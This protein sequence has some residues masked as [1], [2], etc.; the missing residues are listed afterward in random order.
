MVD[1]GQMLG[2]NPIDGVEKDSD[3][4]YWTLI[5]HLDSRHPESD[6]DKTIHN[7]ILIMKTCLRCYFVFGQSHKKTTFQVH[8][9]NSR[10]AIAVK[11]LL[12]NRCAGVYT[13]EKEVGV[14]CPNCRGT[15]EP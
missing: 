14:F 8:I 11:D 4:F 3:E 15:C 10:T 7:T 1:L 9:I 6:H 12:W 13:L 2:M 5:Q